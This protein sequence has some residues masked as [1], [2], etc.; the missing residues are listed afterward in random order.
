MRREIKTLRGELAI[1]RQ[2]RKNSQPSRPVRSCAARFGRFAS[3]VN[4]RRPWLG[5]ELRPPPAVGPWIGV[6]GG[7][8]SASSCGR[9]RAILESGDHPK[10]S[11]G[12]A[13]QDTARVAKALPLASW[14]TAE[15]PAFQLINA[16]VEL[17]VAWRCL[18]RSFRA[19]RW[20]RRGRVPR[21]SAAQV[22]S[23]TNLH[24]VGL[25]A[26]IHASRDS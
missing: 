18:P 2:F 17:V 20:R 13:E 19:N 15:R 4:G 14:R 5:C 3:G 11:E 8:D 25:A 22:A 1:A 9:V 21:A 6:A 12:A 10:A 26:H 23:F 24:R 16:A 7:I